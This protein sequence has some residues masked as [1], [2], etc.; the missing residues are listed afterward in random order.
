MPR[1][2]LRIP[3]FGLFLTLLAG[4]CASRPPLPVPPPK[5]AVPRDTVVLLPDKAGTTG[6]VIVSAS[7]AEQ[8]LSRPMEATRVAS[9]GTPGV[10]FLMDEPAV[11]ALAGGA[12][13]ALP[14]PPARFLLYFSKGTADLTPESEAVLRDATGAI[15]A[16][17]AVD[18]SVVGHSDTLGDKAYNDRLSMKR[19]QAIAARL[20]AGG[21]PASILEITSHG[22]E[23]PL[24]P[25]ADQVAEPKNRRVEVTVR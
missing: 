4:A 10:P 22:K 21:V 20:A 6:V 3:A 14:E 15:K 17:D 13:D 2:T 16:R 9:G 19:A 24:V 7:G 8:R 1:A 23:N 25:T 11:R 18:V 12:M 5:A